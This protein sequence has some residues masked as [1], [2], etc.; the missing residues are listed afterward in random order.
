MSRVTIYSLDAFISQFGTSLVPFL[1]LTVASLPTYRILFKKCSQSVVIH[2][3][4]GFDVV[5]KAEI[6]VFLELSCFF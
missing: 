2:I 3:V 4:K 6:D 1:V 5:N